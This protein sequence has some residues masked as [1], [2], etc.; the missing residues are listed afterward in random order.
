MIDIITGRLNQW[1]NGTGLTPIPALQESEQTALTQQDVI[2]WDSFC[3]GL[4]GN[5]LVDIQKEYL[6]SCNNCT[7]VNA[8]I[9]KMIRKVWDLQKN[10]FDQR[11]GF[12]HS[13]EQA[14]HQF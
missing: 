2:G 6:Q 8:W 7:P 4:V 11:N 5:A 9:S 3:F 1:R 10:I 13:S 14:M 12:L